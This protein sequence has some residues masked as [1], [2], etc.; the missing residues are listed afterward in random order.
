VFTITLTRVGL[1]PGD[2]K[3][4]ISNIEDTP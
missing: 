1:K 4:L 2:T 3:L